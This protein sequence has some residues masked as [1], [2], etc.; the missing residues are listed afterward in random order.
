VTRIPVLFLRM[1]RYRV[2]LTIFLFLAT[3][4]AVHGAPFDGRLLLATFALAASYVAATTAND[5]ADE[6]IDR[7]NHPRDRGRPLV[8]GTA[9][10]GDLWLVHAIAAPAAL[11]VAAP[12]GAP[13]AGVLVA[14]VAIGWMYSLPPIRF[15][16]RTYLAPTTLSV[17]Y[18]LVP[19]A[20][21]LVVAGE[22]PTPRD[23][24]LAA[25]L[26]MLF[27]ARINLKDFRDR[28]GDAAFGKPTLLLRFGKDATCRVSLA[29]L[30]AGDALVLAGLRPT[31]A[32]ALLLQAFV[33]GIVAMLAR[34]RAATDPRE[35]QVAIGIGAKLGNGLLIGV[36]AW[37]LIE[38]RGGDAGDAAL[39]VAALTLAYAWAFVAALRSPGDVVIAYKG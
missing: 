37:A 5:V 10:R 31:L 39:L 35:E 27:V 12:L 6:A 30:L 26:F 23:L 38:A 24:P 2:A 18:V 33:L 17:A 36:L 11:A 34:L 4:V 14:S 21:G 15:A 32:G 3:P 29:A 16:A 22:A 9:T 13:A 20:L 25:G 7:I 19:Y 1:L 28:A 8:D